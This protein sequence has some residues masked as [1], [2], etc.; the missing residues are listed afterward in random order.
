MVRPEFQDH[1]SIPKANAPQGLRVQPAVYPGSNTAP[2]QPHREYRDGRHLGLSERQRSVLRLMML[3]LPNKSICRELGLAEG[4]VKVHVSSILR[5][6][7]ISSRAQVAMAAM[8]SG[9]SSKTS[10]RPDSAEQI[11][12][13]QAKRGKRPTSKRT[14]EPCKKQGET[15]APPTG[16]RLGVTPLT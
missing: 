10:Q 5:I 9:S 4:T 1:L 3:G 15:R 14:W 8:R 12:G 16:A 7:G 11:E 13:E 2:A 6:L